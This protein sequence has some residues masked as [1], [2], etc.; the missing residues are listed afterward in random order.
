MLKIVHLFALL[1]RKKSEKEKLKI[2]CK[3]FTTYLKIMNFFFFINVI[4]HF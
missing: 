2:K 4:S 3:N 1:F